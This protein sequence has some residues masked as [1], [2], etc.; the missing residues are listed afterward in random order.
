MLIII[1]IFLAQIN[2]YS[3]TCKNQKHQMWKSLHK[4]DYILT[5]IVPDYFGSILDIKY[6]TQSTF[7]I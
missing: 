6:I 4:K 1:E 3:I 2:L 5:F 7:N